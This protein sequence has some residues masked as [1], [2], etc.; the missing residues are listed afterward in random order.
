MNNTNV[1]QVYDAKSR[2]AHGILVVT[3]AK[4][5]RGPH[6]RDVHNGVIGGWSSAAIAWPA[7]A[8]QMA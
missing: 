3:A 4:P 7:D 8:E 2:A 1:T 6:G 5:R